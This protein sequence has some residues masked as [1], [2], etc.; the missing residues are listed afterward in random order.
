MY[1]LSHKRTCVCGYSRK[2][3]GNASGE[4]CSFG[5]VGTGEERIKQ[6][7]KKNSSSPHQDSSSKTPSSSLDGEYVHSGQPGVQA[8]I[9]EGFKALHGVGRIGLDYFRVLRSTGDDERVGRSIYDGFCDIPRHSRGR[10]Q[11]G[12]VR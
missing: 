12:F 11:K 1:R 8:A 5:K 3:K 7:A 4:R 6:K 10:W 9:Q 2:R